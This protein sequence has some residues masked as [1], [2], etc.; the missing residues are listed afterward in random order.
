MYAGRVAPSWVTT[1]SSI[2]APYTLGKMGQT[3]VR[4]TDALRLPLNTAS[5]ITNKCNNEQIYNAD[6]VVKHLTFISK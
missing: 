6:A 4:Q 3:D 2:R 5:V 1:L